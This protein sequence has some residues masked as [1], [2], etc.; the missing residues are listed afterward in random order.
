MTQRYFHTGP[1]C[2][3]VVGADGACLYDLA[4]GDMIG[5]TSEQAEL[6]SAC[7][8]GRPAPPPDG[9]GAAFL[10]RLAERGLGCY[11]TTPAYAEKYSV[12]L[13]DAYRD[14]TPVLRL[15]TLFVE[16]T[17][18]CDLDCVFC[19]PGDERLFRRTGC[20]RWGGSGEAL[21]LDDWRSVIAQA[22]GLG[23]TQLVFIGGE[24]TLAFSDLA[25]L[26]PEARA[27]GILRLVLFTNG[28]A[29]DH[30]ALSFLA[31]HGVHVHVQLLGLTDATYAAI[32]G[33]QDGFTAVAA[34]IGALESLG[35]DFDVSLLVT[36]LNEHELTM[37]G[38]EMR[39]DPR[40]LG[41]EYLYPLPPN[42]FHA[43]SAAAAVYERTSR[44]RKVGPERMTH[45]RRFHDCFATTVAVTAEGDIL[46]CP[47]ARALTL[48]NVRS[49]DRLPTALRTPR[50]EQLRSL[51][52]D[53]LDGCAECA[54]RYG[55]D[56][57]RAL[58]MSATGTLT[59]VEFCSRLR[60]AGAGQQ[61]GPEAVDA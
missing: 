54:V 41:V 13:P 58:E 14:L 35:I 52:K 12:G 47:M 60:G 45:L 30:Q 4:S 15:S 2:H 61:A 56:D 19:T 37:I 1:T 39:I 22:A 17:R 46:P 42:E 40:R 57:C 3:T 32:T 31:E 24:P 55:C 9:I 38:D 23:V 10:D 59:G 36:A 33:R 16:L 21:Q 27:T 51:G 29:L 50:A 7:E 25:A 53:K 26:V 43:D 49:G 11:L 5:L 18:E 44:L 28:Y 48:G 8:R 6:L 34:T 20:K